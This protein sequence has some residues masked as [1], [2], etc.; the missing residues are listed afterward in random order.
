MR[1]AIGMP[2]STSP[3][4]RPS[5]L[6]QVLALGHVSRL[7]CSRYFCRHRSRRPPARPAITSRKPGN[8]AGPM[9]DLD[10]R[11]ESAQDLAHA[12]LRA[13]GRIDRL[14]RTGAL[15]ALDTAILLPSADVGEADCAHAARLKLHSAAKRVNR[16][17]APGS[18]DAQTRRGVQGSAHSRTGRWSVRPR[19][20]RSARGW[21]RACNCFEV[22]AGDQGVDLGGRQRAVAQQ[23]LQCAQVGAM[24]RRWV[25]K[26]WRR[27]CGL[28][29]AGI[30][31][32]R[33]G[34]TLDQGPE[35]L[36]GQRIATPARSN[37]AR[38]P[39]GSQRRQQHGA[40]VVQ[41]AL[42]PMLRFLAQRDQAF[43]AALS[44]DPQHA[45][46]RRLAAVA[47]RFQFA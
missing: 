35:R 16:M 22:L 42:Q 25:A 36:P 40:R 31:A 28:I 20:R 18:M 46:C 27:P 11:I 38:A 17:E 45:L 13:A 21:C 6:A 3:R 29:R 7:P 2:W 32:G 39:A 44:G 23:H 43:L 47:G 4:R 33:G 41:V 1:S 10:A 12:R 30:Q 26:L 19:E 37:S 24:V 34:A 5:P 9:V 14:R 15:A 8:G